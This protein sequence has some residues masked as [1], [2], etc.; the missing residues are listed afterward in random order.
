MKSFIFSVFLALLVGASG[1]GQESLVEFSEDIYSK[2]IKPNRTDL[3]PGDPRLN[4]LVPATR[5]LRWVAT[6]SLT[7]RPEILSVGAQRWALIELATSKDATKP[8]V[9]L[10]ENRIV[11]PS[12]ASFALAEGPNDP[13]FGQQRAVL[14]LVG[15]P[16]LWQLQSNGTNLSVAIAIMDTGIQ[17]S[18]PDLFKRMDVAN[19]RSF[20]SSPACEAITNHGT[21][22]TGIAGAETNNNLGIA[23]VSRVPLL[24]WKIFEWREFQGQRV[25]YSDEFIILRA[26]LSV[27]ELPY[28]RVILNCSFQLTDPADPNGFWERAIRAIERKALVVAGSSNESLN[29]S[30]RDTYPGTLSKKLGNVLCLG[31]IDKDGLPSLD[32]GYGDKV[33][34]VA[35]GVSITST[36][37]NSSYGTA[38][39]V[40]FAIPHVSGVAG[41]LVSASSAPPSPSDLKQ[42]LIK[43]ASLNLNLA[44]KM[45]EPRQL[46]GWRSWLALNGQLGD[47]PVLSSRVDSLDDG[48]EDSVFSPAPY[49]WVVIHGKGLSSGY[50]SADQVPLP[51]TLCGVEVLVN[52][53]PMPLLQV[54]PERI[55]LQMEND[56]YMSPSLVTKHSLVIVRVDKEGSQIVGSQ[57]VLSQFTAVPAKPA[58]RALVNSAG[59]LVGDQNPAKTGEQLV[60]WVTGLGRTDPHI[61]PGVPFNGTERV[62]APIEL[63][64]EGAQVPISINAMPCVVGMFGITFVM[65]RVESQYSAKATLCSSVVCTEFW[66]NY[67]HL[68]GAIDVERAT[69]ASNRVWPT[70]KR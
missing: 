53:R 18:H 42:A 1:L 33:E 66:F 21:M 62:V 49:S 51:R 61:Q 25:L 45:P 46:N 40:S 36:S 28:E 15:V 31:S 6:N 50:C 65:P 60:L 12:Q 22:V 30:V 70:Q 11:S 34:L 57:I 43:G 63:L 16:K 32:T 20:S 10:R 4:I 26:F 3:E 67:N 44:E 5:R 55:D 35:P 13:L 48:D 9:F 7:M 37:L 14:E 8:A 19:S 58:V 17:C 29:T 64:F 38:S 68:L 2:L 59:K 39:G 54:G 56:F 47:E 52:N 23:G 24:D 27:L 41:A 69:K